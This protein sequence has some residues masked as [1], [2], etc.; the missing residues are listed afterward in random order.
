MMAGLVATAQITER[1][2]DPV[3]G[4]CE[5]CE[6][7]YE[8]G[9]RI[10]SPVDTLPDF[11]ETEPKLKLTGTVYLQDGH[12]PAADIIL[13]IYHTHRTGIYETRGNETG[14]GRVHGYVRGWIRT[15]KDG[16]YTFYTFRPAAYPSRSEPEHIHLTVKEPGR[17]AY[18]LDSFH[19]EDDPLLTEEERR[20]MSNRGGS[21]ISSPVW[22]ND[23]W[24]VHRDLILGKNIPNYR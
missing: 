10:L 24:T 19:F 12:T 9:D 2:A 4:P 13:Y 22:E 17:N 21:G 15:Q 20:G 3:G 11:K 5:G 6:A 14:W 23:I 18:Y 8:Y 7:I 1:P 16:R